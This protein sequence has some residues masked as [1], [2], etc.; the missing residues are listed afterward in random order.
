MFNDRIKSNVW[1]YVNV[2]EK[3]R[4]KGPTPPINRFNI[5][6]GYRWDG[7]DRSNGWEKKRFT[8]MSD[9]KS[10]EAEKYKWSIENM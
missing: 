5:W 7:V 6:P 10:F 9:Q 3:P 4:Y 8:A 1:R 2:L